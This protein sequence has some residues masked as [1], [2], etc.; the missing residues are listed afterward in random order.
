[1]KIYTKT[2]DDGTTG[3]F[4]GPRVQKCD[5]RIEAYG[6]VDELNSICGVLI[7]EL[8]ELPDGAEKEW[9]V[10]VLRH[11]QADLFCVGSELSA[12]DP[13]KHGLRLVSES[14]ISRLESGID[15][16]ET[17][18]SAL[19]NFILPGG[20]RAAA[21]CHL[22]RTVCR[23]A[24]RRAVRL[25]GETTQSQVVVY[26]NRLSDLFFVLARLANHL[27]G[28]PDVIWHRPQP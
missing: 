21:H 26:L 7:C 3:V 23:R 11:I 16:A 25:L 19:T 4:G 9:M 15:C 14:S 17:H 13:D 20:T 6:T 27:R 2:G 12:P 8:A 18:V 1:M 22:A 28:V 24:E 5:D 10:E